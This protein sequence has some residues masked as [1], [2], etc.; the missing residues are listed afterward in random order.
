MVRFLSLTLSLFP[1]SLLFR[2]DDAVV[3][4]VQTHVIVE[5]CVLEAEI[6]RLDALEDALE[7]VHLDDVD[8]CLWKKASSQ[9]PPFTN[10][11]HGAARPKR[12]SLLYSRA[13][14]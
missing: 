11:D 9:F 4:R 13:T 6:L 12:L 10:Q 7:P 2:T 14:V 3:A 1:F 8:A 5:E